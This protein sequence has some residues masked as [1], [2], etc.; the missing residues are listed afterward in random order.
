[1]NTTDQAD[2]SAGFDLVWVVNMMELSSSMNV[3]TY[4][5]CDVMT[6]P[7]QSALL[8]N[9]GSRK[10][11]MSR[12][13]ITTDSLYGARQRQLRLAGSEY[14]HICEDRGR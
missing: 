10:L 9:V 4:P 1:M 13:I 2:H 6:V 11:I 5:A 14:V 8:C 12:V 7:S 3:E